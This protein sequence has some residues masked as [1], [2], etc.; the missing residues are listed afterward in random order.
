MGSTDSHILMAN[1]SPG[2]LVGWLVGWLDCGGLVGDGYGNVWQHGFDLSMVELKT[3]KDVGD[4][5]YAFKLLRLE[6]E[7]Q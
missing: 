2:S 5:R 3:P 4:L 7:S 1:N 6:M